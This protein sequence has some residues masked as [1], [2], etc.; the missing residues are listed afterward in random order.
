MAWPLASSAQ[1]SPV[2]LIVGDSLSAGYGIP[3]GKEWVHLLRQSLQAREEP[4]QVV[5]ASISG[6]TTS[7]GRSRIEPLLQRENPDWV[8][9][10]LGGNDGLRGISPGVIQQNLTNMIR[11]IQKSQS[12]ALL[13]GVVLP[14]NY[15]RAYLMRFIDVYRKVAAQQ[16]IPL[17]ADILK[18]V[19]GDPTLM[20][21][22]RVHPTLK[23]QQKLLDNVWPTLRKML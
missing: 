1:Q 8:L 23:A 10:E 20:Q 4:I 7:G 5:N 17:V 9:I 2:L 15:G 18:G 12:K 19:G 21:K 22:D 13:V 3:Q 16:D 6:D 11:V 14:P